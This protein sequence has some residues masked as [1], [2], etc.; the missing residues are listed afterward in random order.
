MRAIALV[1]SLLFT[2]AV[3]APRS[4]SAATD[5][6][7]LLA[8]ENFVAGRY[9]EAL[10]LFAKLY[11]EK[12]HPNYLRNIGRCY[13]NLGEPDKAITSFRDYLRKAKN[14]GADE[15]AEVEGYI[16]EMQEMK[17]KREA[18]AAVVPA[19]PVAAAATPPAP[20]A[21]APPAATT[22]APPTTINLVMPPPVTPPPPEVEPALYQK[23]W[24]W[25]IVGG[26]VVAGLGGAAAAGVFTTHKDAPCVGLDCGP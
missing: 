5:Q 17:K 1:V 18:A 10:E 20:T 13:Q 22:T 16:A 3:A 8:R 7:E 15:R 21:S 24:F 6:R 2:S 9:R 11:A 12:L 4:A 26:V 19:A 14:V 23:W 25:A